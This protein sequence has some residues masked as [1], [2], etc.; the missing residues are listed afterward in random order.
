MIKMFRLLVFTILVYVIITSTAYPHP[1]S[2]TTCEPPPPTQPPSAT[3]ALA[4]ARLR[5]L[6][7]RL[8]NLLRN[9]A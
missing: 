2:C 9:P 7:T 5:E 8:A 1:Q 3:L 4:L 6:L